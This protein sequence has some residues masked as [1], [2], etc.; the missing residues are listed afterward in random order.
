[1][2]TKEFIFDRLKE[3]I[4]EVGSKNVVQ[5]VT[6]NAGNCKYA[7]LRIEAHYKNIF[8]TPYVQP[9]QQTQIFG[10]C[11]D[12]ICKSPYHAEEVNVS[13]AIT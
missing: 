13:Q 5:V 1:M 6:D 4:E 7:G 12:K 3:V 9:F 8:W 11:R 10:N 2:K